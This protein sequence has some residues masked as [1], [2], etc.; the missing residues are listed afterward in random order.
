MA[1]SVDMRRANPTKCPSEYNTPDQ[2]FDRVVPASGFRPSNDSDPKTVGHDHRRVDG[3]LRCQEH[4]SRS[5]ESAPTPQTRRLVYSVVFP[6]L[7]R[8]RRPPADT[9]VTLER[10]TGSHEFVKRLV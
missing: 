2:V 4:S 9:L 5:G 8:L 6:T 10:A 7:L 1:R 3:G